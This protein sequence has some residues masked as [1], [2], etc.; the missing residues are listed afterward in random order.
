M[1]KRTIRTT[2]TVITTTTRITRKPSFLRHTRLHREAELRKAGPIVAID[3]VLLQEALRY[4][5]RLGDALDHRGMRYLVETI[6][7]RLE[8]VLA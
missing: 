7:R 8:R 5:E 3:L 1:T 2:K 4:L 6:D